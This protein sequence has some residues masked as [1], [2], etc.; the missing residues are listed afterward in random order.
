VV[1][2]Y[3]AVNASSFS[4]RGRVVGKAVEVCGNAVGT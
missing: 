1:W 3:R 4:F 2:T